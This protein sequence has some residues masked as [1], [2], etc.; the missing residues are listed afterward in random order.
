MLA[1]DCSP[2]G[3]RSNIYLNSAGWFAATFLLDL[4]DPDDRDLTESLELF[5]RLPVVGQD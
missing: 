3:Y 5:L 2:S 4:V 1:A